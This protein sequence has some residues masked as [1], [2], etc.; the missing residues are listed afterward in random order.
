[1]LQRFE[2]FVTGITTCY[3]CIQRIKSMEMTEFGLKGAHVMCLFFLHHNPE[4]LTAAQLCQLC[5]EDKAAISRTVAL[6]QEKGYVEASDRRYRASLRLTEAGQA[7]ALR[8]DHLIAQWVELGSAGL[9]EEDRAAFYR[10][11]EIIAGNLHEAV[12]R[13]RG[14][15]LTGEG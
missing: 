3:K 15:S 7:I 6:L 12:C 5:E 8:I 10:A 13:G 14:F 2:T 1:M 11:L 9:P 4:G